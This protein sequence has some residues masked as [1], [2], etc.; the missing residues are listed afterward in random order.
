M[1]NA[2]NIGLYTTYIEISIYFLDTLEWG[3]KI[4]HTLMFFITAFSDIT[5]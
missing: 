4:H 3:G 1:L 5:L 2:T